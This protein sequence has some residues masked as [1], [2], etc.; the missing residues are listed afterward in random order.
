MIKFV[1]KRIFYA[2][3]VIMSSRDLHVTLN[4]R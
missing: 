3:S 4:K 2:D 1:K